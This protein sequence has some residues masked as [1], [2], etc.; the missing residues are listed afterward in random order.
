MRVLISLQILSE[1]FL[2]PRKIQR[3]SITN[4]HSSS[5]TVPTRYSCQ[6]LMEF[7]FFRQSFEIYS[8]TKYHENPSSLSR[9]LPCGHTNGQTDRHEEANSSFSQFS[10]RA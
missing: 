6:I 3:D 7:V 1:T 10:K 5:C 2:I 9:V 4:V 8:N